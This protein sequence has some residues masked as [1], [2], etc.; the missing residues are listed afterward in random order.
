M[1]D[2]TR[3]APESVQFRADGIPDRVGGM[4]FFWLFGEKADPLPPWWTPARDVALRRYSRQGLVAS[5]LYS[6]ITEIKNLRWTLDSD[7][8][9][10]QELDKYYELLNGVQFGDGFRTLIELYVKDRHTQDNGGFIELIGPGDAVRLN[11]PY[12][13]SDGEGGQREYDAEV[14]AKPPLAKEDITGFAHLDAACM[15]RTYDREYPCIYRNP[16]TGQQHILHYSRVIARAQFRDTLERGRGLGFCSVSRAFDA[17]ELARVN[18]R[19]VFEKM[20]GSE[21]RLAIAR[22]VQMKAILNGLNDAEINNANQGYHFFKGTV[23]VEGDKTAVGADGEPIAF[24]D[25]NNVPDNYDRERELGIAMNLIAIAF[26]TEPRDLGWPATQVGATKADAEVMEVRTSGRGRTDEISDI[27]EWM[28]SRI[29]PHG[30]TFSFDYK[31]DAETLREAEIS[32]TRAETRSIQ[33]TSGEISADEARQIAARDGDIPVTFLENQTVLEADDNSEAVADTAI[34]SPPDDPENQADE[35]EKRL[36]FS[37]ISYDPLPSDYKA[38]PDTTR[39]FDARM[40]R[41]IKRATDGRINRRDFEMALR[42][43]VQRG[44][45]SAYADGIRAGYGA[46]S[47]SVLNRFIRTNDSRALT[48]EQAD[49][50]GFLV[51]EQET[52]YGTL[53]KWIYDAQP[54]AEQIK[55]RI[56]L[57]KHKSVEDAYFVGKLLARPNAR[58]MWKLGKTREHCET[59]KAADGQIHT[60]REWANRRLHPRS[61]TCLCRGFNCDCRL[62]TTRQAVKGDIKSIPLYSGLIKHG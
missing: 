35:T 8:D 48:P 57:W 52:Y 28:N 55:Y 10:P 13:T 25:L 38:L 34:E 24:Y 20:T 14:F 39:D 11:V 4:D 2:T 31:D 36:G 30:I 12:W 56:G 40:G 1:L 60:A 17:L 6:R 15:W 54:D 46:Q 27:E 58:L 59:C 23:F 47:R 44:M 19:Y 49:S 50:L 26:G 22:N 3:Q 62:V 61:S 29:L 45:R 43:E 18:N 5:I 41:L 51:K 16:Y 9:D 33:I 37:N 21:P 7:N 42:Q 32:R 53:T